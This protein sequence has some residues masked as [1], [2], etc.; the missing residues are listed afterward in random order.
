ML[1]TGPKTLDTR[2]LFAFT[3]PCEPE[4]IFWYQ[5]DGDESLEDTG[6]TWDN[7]PEI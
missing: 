5:W 4:Y 6:V 3:G 2:T 1:G 7:F